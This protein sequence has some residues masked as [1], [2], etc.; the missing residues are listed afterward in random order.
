[1]QLGHVQEYCALNPT[2]STLFTGNM[3]NF[4]SHDLNSDNVQWILHN[5]ALADEIY[6]IKM[7]AVSDTLQ[8]STGRSQ[9]EVRDHLARIYRGPLNV[10]VP[11]PIVPYLRNSLLQDSF[12]YLLLPPDQRSTLCR[13]Q[14]F[15]KLKATSSHMKTTTR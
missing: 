4:I 14:A 1:M 7:G 11:H 6:K 9:E 5:A 3:V 13:V 8:L 12:P 15:H 2:P 10:L